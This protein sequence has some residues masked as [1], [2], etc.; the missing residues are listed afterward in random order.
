VQVTYEAQFRIV[1]AK[2]FNV[3][4]SMVACDVPLISDV[5]AKF[6]FKRVFALPLISAYTLTDSYDLLLLVA[7]QLVLSLPRDYPRIEDAPC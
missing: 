4:S 1:D 3:A 5:D 2:R 6:I 7:D